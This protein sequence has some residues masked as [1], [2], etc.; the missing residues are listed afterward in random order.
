[1]LHICCKSLIHDVVDDTLLLCCVGDVVDSV[2]TNETA[3]SVLEHQSHVA[4]G[5]EPIAEEDEGLVTG[6]STASE[7]VAKV[8][9]TDAVFTVHSHVQTETHSF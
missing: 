8:T 2:D 7:A 3:T 6:A 5:N 4:T 1:M 9:D